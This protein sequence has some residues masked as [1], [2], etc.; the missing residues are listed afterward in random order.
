[1]NMDIAHIYWVC[2]RLI[3]CEDLMS[4]DG[5]LNQW[6]CTELNPMC[7]PIYCNW[8]CGKFAR[9]VCIKLIA[10]LWVV[11]N[12]KLLMHLNLLMKSW[13]IYCVFRMHHDLKTHILCVNA[14]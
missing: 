11:L 3:Y 1:M 14:Y 12:L 4:F 10:M 6:D 7:L 2:K 8:V 9:R 5:E 13:I